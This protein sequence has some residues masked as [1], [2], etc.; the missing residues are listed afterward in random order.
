VTGRVCGAGLLTGL[1]LPAGPWPL[2]A[3]LTAAAV[4]LAAAVAYAATRGTCYADPD[5]DCPDCRWAMR[6]P[7][8]DDQEAP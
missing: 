8:G 4:A 2:V 7:T 6:P 1:W 5:C 3:F